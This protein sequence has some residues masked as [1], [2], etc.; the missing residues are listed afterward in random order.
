MT[1]DLQKQHPRENEII[2]FLKSTLEQ[3]KE[4]PAGWDVETVFRSAMNIFPWWGVVDN[5][6]FANKDKKEQEQIVNF[7]WIVGCQLRKLEEEK[8]DKE[9]LKSEEAYVLFKQTLERIKFESKEEKIQMLKS[10]LLKSTLQETFAPRDH[11]EKEYIL[12][13]IIELD[14]PHLNILKW[15]FD[16]KFLSSAGVGSDYSQRKPKE[17][18]LI[19]KYYKEF[20]NDLM[21]AGLLEDVSAGRLG[22][23]EHY[24]VPSSLGKVVFNFIK[25]D[26]V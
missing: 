3:I 24:Y 20:E 15:Y 23:A 25:Y 6:L 9:F 17:L 2:R 11:V 19:S 8:L 18:S 14:I 5:L 22:S 12:S 10:F 1:S 26:D 16:N 4:I 7:L 21:V 13:K